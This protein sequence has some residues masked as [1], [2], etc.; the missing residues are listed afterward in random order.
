MKQNIL[1]KYTTRSALLLLQSLKFVMINES[2][3]YTHLEL[4]FN[5]PGNCQLRNTGF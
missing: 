4:V 1:A 3:S 2:Q 5:K